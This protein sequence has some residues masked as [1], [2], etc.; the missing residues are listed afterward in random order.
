MS[1]MRVQ[2][3]MEDESEDEGDR[4]K[5]L[6]HPGGVWPNLQDGRKAPSKSS[7][8][9]LEH[10]DL[11]INYVRNP[12]ANSVFILPCLFPRVVPVEGEAWEVLHL[13]SWQ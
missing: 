2:R 8:V 4:R 6:S 5:I 10:L 11:Q 3:G 12:S 1:Q 13:G 7:C 9:S